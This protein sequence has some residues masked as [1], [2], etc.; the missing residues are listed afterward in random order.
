MLGV[1]VLLSIFLSYEL[2]FKD[3]VKENEAIKI[4]D[5]NVIS[6]KRFYSTNPNK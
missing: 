6:Y 4:D 5:K 2:L 1:L 3:Q